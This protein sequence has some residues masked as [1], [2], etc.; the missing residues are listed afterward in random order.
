MGPVR[1]EK[2]KKGMVRT[3]KSEGGDSLE[4]AGTG[5]DL[6]E[7][8]EISSTQKERRK[9]ARDTH[10]CWNH[11]SVN[12]PAVAASSMQPLG[13]TCAYV[14]IFKESYLSII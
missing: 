13:L 10:I 4:R 2:K 8:S 1:T 5:L 6:L 9:K 11:C 7:R 14:K 12:L 3:E